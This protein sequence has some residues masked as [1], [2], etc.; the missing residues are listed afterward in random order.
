MAWKQKRIIG[1][2]FYLLMSAPLANG[3]IGLKQEN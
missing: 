2:K 1:L 3:Q